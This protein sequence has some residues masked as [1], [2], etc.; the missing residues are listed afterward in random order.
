VVRVGTGTAACVWSRL[1]RLTTGR[2]SAGVHR[3]SR[4]D[5]IDSSTACIPTS[6]ISLIRRANGCTSRRIALTV[7]SRS[8]FTCA[9][10]DTIGVWSREPTECFVAHVER[11][12]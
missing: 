5:G 1:A 8:P 3:G 7:S 6:S 12:C 4:R 2:N 9:R 11:K 10:H